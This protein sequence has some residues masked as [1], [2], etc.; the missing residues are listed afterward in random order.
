VKIGVFKE[1]RS[2][3][4]IAAFAPVGRDEDPKAK[5]SKEQMHQFISASYL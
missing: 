2:V 3:Y 1:G 4:L 5:R